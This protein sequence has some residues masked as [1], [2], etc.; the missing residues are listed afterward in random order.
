MRHGV[1]NCWGSWRE[2]RSWGTPGEACGENTW[3]DLARAEMEL[4]N[5]NRIFLWVWLNPPVVLS[6]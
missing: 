3:L 5:E 2:Y 6:S 4:I 1:N